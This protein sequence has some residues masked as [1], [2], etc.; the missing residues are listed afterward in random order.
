MDTHMIVEL[1]GYTGSA[2]VLIS[3]FLSSVVKLRMLNAIGGAVF[4]CY[5]VLIH[6]L[7]T[8]F[9]NSCLV[10]VNVWYLLRLRKDSKHYDLIQVAMEDPF[11][12]YLLNHFKDDISNFFPEWDRETCDADVAYVVLC[13]TVP[14][15]VFLGKQINQESLEMIF[16]YAVP[17][18]RDCS[19]GRYLYGKLA[20]QGICELKFSKKTVKY[21]D[22]LQKVGFVKEN[23][24]FIKRL[25]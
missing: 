13:D 24:T 23:D 22:Y 1:I 5:A 12:D 19:V 7:P 6:S 16:E 20:T 18:Y 15:G 2:L 8:A 11:L 4:A 10:L 25:K 17:T 21:E 3:F 9:M 14:A